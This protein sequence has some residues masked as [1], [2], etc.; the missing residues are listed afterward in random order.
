MN[1]FGSGTRLPRPLYS[2][3]ERNELPADAVAASLGCGNP[4]AVADLH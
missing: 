4:M 1:W 2:T 3:D